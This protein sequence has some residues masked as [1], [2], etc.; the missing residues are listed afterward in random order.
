MCL[1]KSS[2]DTPVILDVIIPT[3]FLYF[4]LFCY[5][6]ILLHFKCFLLLVVLLYALEL[7]DQLLRSWQLTT[8]GD[9]GEVQSTL[10]A[11]ALLRLQPP[12]QFN[13]KNPDN[14]PR[15]KRRFQQF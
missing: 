11:M 8:H 10:V 15:W 14:W 6:Y 13:F 3:L 9:S 7:N 1:H 12:E 5:P 4:L 2:T